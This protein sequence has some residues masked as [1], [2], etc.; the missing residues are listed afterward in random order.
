MTSPEGLGAGKKACWGRKKAASVSGIGRH[1]KG[2]G[3]RLYLQIG[4]SIQRLQ[5]SESSEGRNECISSPGR[6]ETRASE[7]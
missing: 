3:G 4:D 6:V 5:V 7:R 1:G 2:L